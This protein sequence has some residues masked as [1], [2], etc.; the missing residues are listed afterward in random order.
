[1]YQYCKS[2]KGAETDV[3]YGILFIIRL[4][5]GWDILRYCDDI[6]NQLQSVKQSLIYRNKRYYCIT[7]TT[8]TNLAVVMKIIQAKFYPILSYLLFHSWGVGFVFENQD[9]EPD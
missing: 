5:E 6:S 4:V 3:D 1:M 9:R 8:E 2:G 7:E